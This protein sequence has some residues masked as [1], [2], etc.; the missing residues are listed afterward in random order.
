MTKAGHIR[1]DNGKMGGVVNGDLAPE[2]PKAGP[3]F[4][5]MKEPVVNS[6][7]GFVSN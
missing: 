3:F 5:F 1:K 7:A 4:D 6:T 2:Y